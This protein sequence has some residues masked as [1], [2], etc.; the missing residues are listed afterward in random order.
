MDPVQLSQLLAALAQQQAQVQPRPAQPVNPLASLLQG[1]SQGVPP[2]APA[3]NVTSLL[4]ALATLV[5]PAASAQ[6]YLPQPAHS[7]QRPSYDDSYDSKRGRGPMHD[8]ESRFPPSKVHFHVLMAKIHPY[9]FRYFTCAVYLK[10]YAQKKFNRFVH[11]LA[12]LL[13]DRSR[14]FH[15]TDLFR[16]SQ[17]CP[18][19]IKLS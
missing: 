2:Q 18:N 16:M 10:E 9:I 5:N 7:T 17:S 12:M 1:V 6:S 15:A 3:P 8:D 14:C 13:A 11:S 4:S 19:I